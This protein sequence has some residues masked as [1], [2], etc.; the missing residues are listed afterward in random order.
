MSDI[1]ERLRAHQGREMMITPT[2][3][4]KFQRD[5]VNRAF[6]RLERLSSGQPLVE[7]LRTHHYSFGSIGGCH[8]CKDAECREAADEIERLEDELTQ[9]RDEIERL[10]EM[11]LKRDIEIKKMILKGV[12]K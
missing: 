5:A 7:R 4:G 9:A 6:D 2:Q 3:Y 12:V 1:K 10:R 8:G 11:V